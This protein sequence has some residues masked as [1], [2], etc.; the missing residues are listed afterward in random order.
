MNT[1]NNWYIALIKA[2][3][4]ARGVKKSRLKTNG[5]K[6]RKWLVNRDLHPE[7]GIGIT[8]GQTQQISWTDE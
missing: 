2:P 1:L 8:I 7:P 5:L 4:F 6:F 3:T